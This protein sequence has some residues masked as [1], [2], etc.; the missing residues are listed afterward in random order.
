[1]KAKI[2]VNAGNLKQL[3]RAS[4]LAK[5]VA[6]GLTKDEDPQSEAMFFTLSIAGFIWVFAYCPHIAYPGF[7]RGVWLALAILAIS[8]LLGWG[9]VARNSCTEFLAAITPFAIDVALVS[10]TK[11]DL[12]LFSSITTQC[13]VCGALIGTVIGIGTA[14]V[15]Y[16]IV[17]R[18]NS[19]ARAL[20]KVVKTVL[21]SSLCSV[22]VGAAVFIV[23]ACFL[24]YG[25]DLTYFEEKMIEQM[26]IERILGNGDD[27][28]QH[29]LLENGSSFV[30]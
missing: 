11:V 28:G 24:N 16:D 27:R 5:K 8:L 4:L 17:R 13:L 7:E 14:L 19:L 29:N 9:P 2:S 1:M 18:G 30:C 22:I 3:V 15:D 10:L 25:S 12:P 20:R 21:V 23:V 6:E 26:P